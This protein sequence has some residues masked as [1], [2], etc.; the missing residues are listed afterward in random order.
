[1]D[2]VKGARKTNTLS[3]NTYELIEFVFEIFNREVINNVIIR[4]TQPSKL[5]FSIDNNSLIRRFVSNVII[6]VVVVFSTI[7]SSN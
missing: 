6:L 1:M 5:K 3:H 7:S 2:L 4:V